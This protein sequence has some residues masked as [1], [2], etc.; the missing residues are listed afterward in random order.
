MADQPKTNKTQLTKPV[1][2]SSPAS[3]AN[4]RPVTFDTDNLSQLINGQLPAE[5][6]R[7]IL[8]GKDRR[9]LSAVAWSAIQ[10]A[11]SAEKLTPLLALLE[12]SEKESNTS[13]MILDLLEAQGEA[14]ARMEG[15]LIT[16]ESKIDGLRAR[17]PT[18]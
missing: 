18:H 10:S 16:L 3:S 1:P 5:K 9:G 2:A 17:F 12:P 8:Q 13:Q 4:P 7:E 15:K 6:T 11:I 14:I